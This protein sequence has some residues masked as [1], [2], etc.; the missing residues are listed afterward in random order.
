[1]GQLYSIYHQIHEQVSFV[2]D[3]CY[4]FNIH[5]RDTHYEEVIKWWGNVCNNTYYTRPDF[6]PFLQFMSHEEDTIKRLVAEG[7]NNKSLG[8]Y[9]V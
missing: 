7:R 8:S 6:G 2:R 3:V 9:I 5:Q 4:E 1:M